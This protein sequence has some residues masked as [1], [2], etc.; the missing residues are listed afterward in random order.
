M[1]NHASAATWNQAASYCSSLVEGGYSGWRLPSLSELNGM[2][3]DG[4]ANYLQLVSPSFPLWSSTTQGNKAY[5][6]TPAT[7]GSGY[8]LK[9]S[10][11]DFVCVR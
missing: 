6:V 4:G 9:G 5:A 2:S 10:G 7:D 3:L 1:E 11:L 8:F